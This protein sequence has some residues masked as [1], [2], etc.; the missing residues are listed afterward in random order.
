M[1]AFAQPWVTAGLGHLLKIGVGR[2]RGRNE[3]FLDVAHHH[4]VEPEGRLPRLE[5]GA[6]QVLE[7][8]TPPPN[9]LQHS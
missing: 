3:T 1:V 9:K 5:G 7:P 6:R 8:C 2:R 4:N